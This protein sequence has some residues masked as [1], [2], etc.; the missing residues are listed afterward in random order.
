M[1]ADLFQ[2]LGHRLAVHRRHDDGGTDAAFRTDGTE[3]IG[4]V[5]AVVA[6]R[7]RSRSATRPDV[8]ER[9]LLADAGLISEPDLQ[10]LAGGAG[11]YCFGYQAGKAFLKAA[12]AA[13]SFF[14]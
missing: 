11:W 2:V 10:R 6:N 13:T 5:V 9:A 3:E 12:C 1:G 8:G 14:G 7:R 4:G